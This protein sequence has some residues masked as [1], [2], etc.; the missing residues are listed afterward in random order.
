MKVAGCNPTSLFD[1]VGIN[2]VLFV[3]GCNHRCPHCHN[4]S[5]WDFN[6]GVD[7]PI[8]DIQ[9][10][11]ERFLPLISGLTLSGGDPVYQL[12]DAI[13]LARWAK[14]IDLKVTLYTGFELNQIQ[15]PSPSPFDFIID[16]CFEFERTD[17]CAFR[18]SSNQK[19]W[20][21]FGDKYY[22]NI[23]ASVD[24]LDSALYLRPY[25]ISSFQRDQK[26]ALVSDSSGRS[27]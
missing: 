7:M 14:T 8:A 20:S 3:Q 15:L 25:K 21:R 18:G 22:S 5:T 9:A 1:G 6:G 27:G 12:D 4:P 23:S 13:E 16:G 24:F 10:D 11:I 19:V 26:R 2:Y 17:D